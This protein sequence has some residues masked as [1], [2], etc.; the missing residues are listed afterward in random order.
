MKLFIVED[1]DII[2]GLL[3]RELEKWNYE[4]SLSRDFNNIMGEFDIHR[5]HLVLM[6]I[7]LPFYNGYYWC[8]EIRKVSNV[9]IVFISSK[10]DNMDIIMAMQFGG[11][12][13]ITKPINTD[14]MIAKIRAILRRSYEFITNIDYI[15]FGDVR[16]VLSDASVEYKDMKIGITKTEM[17]ILESLF[18]AKGNI[19]SKDDLIENCWK[20]NNFIDD[21][22]LAVNIARLRKK[23]SGIGLNSIIE[24]K[25]GIGYYLNS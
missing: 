21:N 22:T 23:L 11:D 6:D 24:T 15:D 13:Y 2:A 8:Q 19:V 12:D 10:T 9:P 5:P 17:M 16:L 14:V 4:V 1:D 3:K 18:K 20:S 7:N 25:K